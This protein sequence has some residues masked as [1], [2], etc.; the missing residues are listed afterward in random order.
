MGFQ[1]KPAGRI[2]AAVGV[3]RDEGSLA[4]V[5]E[6]SVAM[7]DAEALVA[8]PGLDAEAP[9]AEP[10]APDAEAPDVELAARGVV[11]LAQDVPEVP[12]FAAVAPG[13]LAA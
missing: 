13:V 11:V 7:P 4:S 12:V 2:S 5:P 8:A 10:A 6:A 3:P 9:V 1:L